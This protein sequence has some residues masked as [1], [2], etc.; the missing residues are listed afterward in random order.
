MV[1]ARRREVLDQLALVLDDE[2]APARSYPPPLTAM[3]VASGV[4]GVVH[5]QLSQPQAGSLVELAGALMSFTVQ[6]FL[7]VKA[8]RRELTRP[9][10]TDVA[11]QLASS[12]DLIRDAAGRLNPRAASVLQAIGAGPGLNNR[13]IARRAEVTDEGQIS[14]VLARLQRLGLIEDFSRRD[15]PAGKA[16]QLTTSGEVV[17]AAIAREAAAPEPVSAFDLPQE[18]LGRLEDRAVLTL[19]VIGDQPWLRTAEV[20]ERAGIDDGREHAALLQQ[21]V[22]LGLAV[23]ERERHQR[24]T[25]KAWRLTPAGEHL[26]HAIGCEAPVP[27]RSVARDLMWESG[28]RLSEDAT[29]ALRVIGSEPALS[30]NEIATRVGIDDENSMS[31]LLARLAKRGL[32]ENVRTGGRENAW[33]LT[34]AGECLERAIWNEMP[35]AL[36]RSLALDLVRDRG[37]RLNHRVVSVLRIIAAEHGLSNLEISERAGI[38]AKGHTSTFLARLARFGLIE[39]LVLDPAP[40]EANAWQLTGLGKELETA[41][42]GEGNSPLATPGRPRRGRL[43]IAALASLCIFAGTLAAT[44]PAALA[45]PEYLNACPTLATAFCGPGEFAFL[46]GIALD[47]TGVTPGDVYAID[48]GTHELKRFNANGEELLPSIGHLGGVP[49]WDAVDNSTDASKGDIYVAFFETPGRVVK[50][51]PAGS[52]VAGF[53]TGGELTTPGEA[54]GVAVD[55]STGHL[56]VATRETGAVNEF[57]SA[58]T[59]LG[60]FTVSG[61]GPLDGIAVDPYGDVFAVLEG[62]EIVEYP[63]SNRAEPKVIDGGGAP[64]EVTADVLTGDLYI[65]ESASGSVAVYEPVGGK[66]GAEKGEFSRLAVP[67]LEGIAS[68]SYGL[69]V[70]ASTHAVYIAD[71]T[72]EGAI[73]QEP[74]RG[75]PPPAPTVQTATEVKGRTAIL[76]GTLNPVGPTEKLKYHFSYSTGTTCTSAPST[77]TAV[78][79]LPGEEEDVPAQASVAGLSGKTVYKVCLFATNGGGS[80]QSSN[81]ESFETEPAPPTVTEESVSELT[82]TTAKVSATVNPSGASTTCELQY[83]NVSLSEHKQACPALAEP[84]AAT[85]QPVTV[86]LSGLTPGNRY[87]Y[88][89]V[90]TNTSEGGVQ[91]VEGAEQ[92]FETVPTVEVETLPAGELTGESALLAGAVKTGPEGGSYQFEYSTKPLSEPGASKTKLEVLSGETSGF[93]PVSVSVAGLEPK[94]VYHFRVVG[95]SIGNPTTGLFGAEGTRELE[96]T[97]SAA[98]PAV[99]VDPVNPKSIERT[100]AI[101]SGTVDAEKSETFYHF[102]YEYTD[103]E[104]HAH[105]AQTPTRK[106]PFEAE[107]EP[108]LTPI[109][110]GPA[111]IEELK[112]GT[113]YRYR[114][115]ASNE[116]GTITS[117]QRTFTSRPPQPPVIETLTGAATSQTTATINATISANG[118]ATSYTLETGPDASYGTQIFGHVPEHGTVTANVTGLLP[119]ST[120][121][122]RVLAHNQDGDVASADASFTTPGFPETLAPPPAPMATLAFTPLP[123]T[124]NVG[125]PPKAKPPTRAQLLAKAVKK[126]A[127]Q[128]KRK[129]AK[130]VRE[131]RRNFGR[132]KHKEHK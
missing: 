114:I 10:H 23:G 38:E 64:H 49:N 22:D 58:G 6:P 132:V 66:A 110:T 55:P 53:G 107:N 21:L 131:A 34:S 29:S 11:A 46:R 37:G 12:P 9:A 67:G 57:S 102:E 72:G 48:E 13:G 116:A 77:T 61:G 62:A 73:F 84:E 129:R 90:A 125:G 98:K 103:A 56:L 113:A 96:L 95:F 93:Q 47:N 19:R 3:A 30:N 68:F 42:A 111:A 122:F 71:G 121:H 51:D 70:N 17:E 32:V 27:P 41:I 63:V 35:P 65:L 59:L 36:Q 87:R 2:C 83:G 76:H 26:D 20:A 39:N 78:G 1:Q 80:T 130:C 4:L 127:K 8:A 112:P 99:V 86:E 15:A 50:V 119:G 91:A 28:G 115:I 124:T 106:L 44:A 85:A 33:V 40:F 60:S 123:E 89:L 25:P 81:Q 18:F 126:C 54:T 74:F 16:W 120:I 128:P 31:Q 82:T 117:P 104:D 52:L 105:V 7:G 75:P 109:P 69:A 88:R 14:R 24:G 94:A 108:G 45:A 79:E 92:E 43:P 118:L 101:L 97:T 5:A 100:S